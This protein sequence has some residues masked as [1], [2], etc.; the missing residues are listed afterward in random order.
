MHRRCM[1]LES[2]ARECNELVLRQQ[3]WLRESLQDPAAHKK[4]TLQH[5]F[6]LTQGLRVEFV[7]K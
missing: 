1:P 4:K 5:E 2:D 7:E 6:T 3:L